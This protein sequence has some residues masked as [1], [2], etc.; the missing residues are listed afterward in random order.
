MSTQLALTSRPRL[1]SANVARSPPRQSS[2]SRWLQDVTGLREG[3][4]REP[5]PLS[6]EER[7]QELKEQVFKNRYNHEPPPEST[8]SKTRNYY[9]SSEDPSTI[10]T[11]GTS[12][13]NKQNEAS[14]LGSRPHKKRHEG[15]KEL[16]NARSRS[17]S[18]RSSPNTSPVGPSFNDFAEQQQRVRPAKNAHQKTHY[19]KREHQSRSPSKRG[20]T[21]PSSA[22]QLSSGVV[23]QQ[24]QNNT[25]NIATPR[26]ESALV[27]HSIAPQGT[28]MP[29]NDP[30]SQ[31][32]GQV[33][34]SKSTQETN[35]VETA[36]LQAIDKAEAIPALVAS[37]QRGAVPK[38]G[39]FGKIKPT[40]WLR[41][42]VAILD[43]SRHLPGTATARK[44]LHDGDLEP[45]T[46]PRYV[47]ETSPLQQQLWLTEIQKAFNEVRVVEEMMLDD[48]ISSPA[49][50]DG[51]TVIS[52]PTVSVNNVEPAPARH[53][54]Y[55]IGERAVESG[56]VEDDDDED[57]VSSIQVLLNWFCSD[58]PTTPMRLNTR[59]HLV[60]STE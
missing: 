54:D 25:I 53:P 19:E 23:K 32:E 43:A 3:D 5:P 16:S 17:P 37:S 47:N 21:N 7:L 60:I 35:Q 36:S 15:N 59:G 29:K 41:R 45:P 9:H 20:T 13:K 24:K 42:T 39:K 27:E 57:S 33:E 50:E 56:S 18:K 6:A 28:D 4:Q 52:Q 48:G 51:E 26:E 11:R 1:H 44:V 58:A 8:L 12:Y 38:K 31:Q 10:N 34:A 55:Y 30:N 14:M 46:P 2:R 40:S 22:D 49:D